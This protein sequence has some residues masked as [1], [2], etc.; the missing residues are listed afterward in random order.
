MRRPSSACPRRPGS[1]ARRANARS[2]WTTT[3]SVRC[4]RNSSSSSATT[5]ESGRVSPSGSRAAT[6]TA[7]DRA[8]TTATSCSR[9]D[10]D[11]RRGGFDVDDLFEQ[12]PDREVRR[13]GLVQPALCAP[14]RNSGRAAL[15]LAEESALARTPGSP[16]IS[17]TPP[18]PCGQAVDER[19]EPG[20]IVVTPD[21]GQL[22]AR[23]L[24]AHTAC[25]SRPNARSPAAACP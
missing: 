10:A 24:G 22:E 13:C 5:S 11:F 15:D 18:L 4:F 20:Q 25:R 16:T 19:R 12:L 23:D 21:E 7:A 14:H 1:S 9:R 2:N 8:R 6:A 3:S 17:M